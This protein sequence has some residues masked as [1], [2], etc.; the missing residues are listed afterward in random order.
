MRRYNARLAAALDGLFGERSVQ[1]AL[2]F[3]ERELI[4]LGLHAVHGSE[5]KVT[6][7]GR[8]PL[9]AGARAEALSAPHPSR[10]TSAG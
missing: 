1:S 6:E 3:E 7:H 10:Q 4:L 9:E 2:G 8:N 5:D